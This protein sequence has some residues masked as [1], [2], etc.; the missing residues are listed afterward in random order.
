M[1]F[2]ERAADK[3]LKSCGFGAKGSCCQARI[4]ACDTFSQNYLRFP[5]TLF[6]F[7]EEPPRKARF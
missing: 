2:Q 1:D 7:S 6:F 3:G 5:K 4:M